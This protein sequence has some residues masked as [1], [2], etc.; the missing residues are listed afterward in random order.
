MMNLISLDDVKEAAAR[1]KGHIRQTPVME[2]T[3]LRHPISDDYRLFLK[4]EQAQVTGS[5]KARGAL[6][7]AL[8][9]TEV[10]LLKGLITA[11]GG[12]HGLGVAYAGWKLGVPASIYLPTTTPEDKVKKLEALKADVAIIGD[13]WDDANKAALDAVKSTGQTYIHPFAQPSIIA[14]QGTLALELL[15]QILNIDVLLVSIGGGGL[16]S[17]IALCAKEINPNIKI[18]GVEPVG[19]ATL[20]DS[21]KAGQL[22]TL[23][24]INTKAGTLAPRRSDVLNL[25]II[26]KYVDDI[27]LV[28]DDDLQTAARWLWAELGQAVELSAAAGIAALQS[29]AYKP[30]KGCRVCSIL[31]GVG[32]D[33]F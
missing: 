12:N 28:T 9:L 23:P 4:L 1:I 17:G 30:A 18:I 7:T 14:G 6:N 33:G 27:V 16:I 2:A 24:A 26:T 20:H 21:V 13:V 8:G 32:K 15:D 25:Q 19:A 3:S 29:G 10:E 5:F 11:S 31:C 22:I